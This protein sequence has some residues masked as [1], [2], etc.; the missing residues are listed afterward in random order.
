[1]GFFLTDGPEV[2]RSAHNDDMKKNMNTDDLNSELYI[3]LRENEVQINPSMDA[4]HCQ[5]KL[6]MDACSFHMSASMLA[7]N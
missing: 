1:V 5:E 2:M 6:Y 4:C 7:I 3:F